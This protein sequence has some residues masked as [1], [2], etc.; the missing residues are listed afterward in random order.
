MLFL[1]AH[2]IGG[3]FLTNSLVLCFSNNAWVSRTISPGKNTMF[4]RAWLARPSAV[5]ST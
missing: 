3:L 4:P 5:R 2:E 1:N